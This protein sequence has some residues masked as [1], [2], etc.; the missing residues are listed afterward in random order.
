L[1]S[2][3]LSFSSDKL[4]ST[5]VLTST[6]SPSASSTF[7]PTLSPSYTPTPLPTVTSTPLPSLTPTVTETSAPTPTSILPLVTV[8]EQAN[9]R[10]GPGKAY[11]YAQG[12]YAGDT[13]I[14]GG[15]NYNGTWVWIKPDKSGWYCFAALS[16]L[17][18]EKGRDILRLPVSHWPLPH[19]TFYSPPGNV[20]AVRNGGKVTITWN[21]VKMTVDDDR[22]YLI[23]ANVCQ[24]G[25]LVF[26]AVNPIKPS[27]VFSDDQNCSEKSNGLLYTVD[28]HGY[29]N[30]VKI[31]WPK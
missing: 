9:C 15:R 14:A 29:S 25:N 24:N 16:V 21:K 1:A 11:L 12:L 23:E 18:V 6:A 17:E 5:Q 7:L 30:P 27:Y 22:G 2:C 3:K 28:K 10:Y 8:K 4:Q 26:M 31:P 20:Q 13:G 19:S